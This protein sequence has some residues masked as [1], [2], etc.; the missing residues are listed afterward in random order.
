MSKKEEARMIRRMVADHL[1]EI[2]FREE[3]VAEYLKEYEQLT[4]EPMYKE[5]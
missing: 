1:A 3:L 5:L 2:K 4:G